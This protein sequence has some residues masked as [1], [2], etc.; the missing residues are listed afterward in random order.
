MKRSSSILDYNSLWD[1]VLCYS[2]GSSKEDNQSVLNLCPSVAIHMSVF[3]D[4]VVCD[5]S[6][7]V[8]AMFSHRIKTEFPENLE[9][10]IVA[11][12]ISCLVNSFFFGTGCPVKHIFSYLKFSIEKGRA[13]SQLKS[14]NL[15]SKLMHTYVNES[16]HEWVEDNSIPLKS[17]SLKSVVDIVKFINAYDLSRVNFSEFESI[18]YKDV[19]NN[20]KTCAKLVEINLSSTNITDVGIRVLLMNCLNLKK[21]DLSFCQE[22]NF[23]Y[24]NE[25]ELFN[26]ELRE[27]ILSRV[28]V[29][30]IGLKKLLKASPSLKKISFYNSNV[31]DKGLR[32]ISKNCSNLETIFLYFDNCTEL[33]LKDLAKGCPKLEK[34]GL[35]GVDVSE[36]GLK[37]LSCLSLRE[38]DLSHTNVS[39][40]E[41]GSFAQGS[42]HL[43]LISLVS[44][45]V[46]DVGVKEL[47]NACPNLKKI[48][49]AGT[50]VTSS[51][52]LSLRKM[53]PGLKILH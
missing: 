11:N 39:D 38:I 30:G 17:F 45:N 29:F 23:E 3:E 33:G 50:S 36:L 7:Q 47:V 48:Y 49:L 14:L 51:C 46:T 28:K 1:N 6:R 18:K 15:V 4:Y 35:L 10:Q 53:H 31:G 2:T 37:A 24:L 43:T 22:V 21:I 20:Y 26:L 16:M 12:D 19:I 13:T 40:V 9:A 44:T 34:I 5:K 27:L 32:A 52:V 41:L 42:P 8:L 25:Y